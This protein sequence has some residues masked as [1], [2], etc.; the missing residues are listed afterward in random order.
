MDDKP[1][2]KKLNHRTNVE[3]LRIIWPLLYMS[4]PC[5]VNQGT[6]DEATGRS[7]KSGI[8]PI[9]QICLN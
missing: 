7:R 3:T 5:W 1:S 9:N 8:S 4:L 6:K 2:E